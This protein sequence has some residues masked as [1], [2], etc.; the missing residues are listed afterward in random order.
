MANQAIKMIPKDKLN[1]TSKSRCTYCELTRHP[2][3][4]FG[5]LQRDYLRPQPQHSVR[6]LL[7]PCSPAHL[8]CDQMDD[9]E[10]EEE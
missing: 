10:P 8:S 9:N 4:D 3:A 6:Q 1:V 2:V 5:D 7:P